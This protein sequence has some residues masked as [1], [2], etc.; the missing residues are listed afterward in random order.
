MAFTIT[1][2]IVSICVIDAYVIGHWTCNTNITPLKD[3]KT[4]FAIAKVIAFIIAFALVALCWVLFTHQVFPQWLT[5]VG[6]Q[7]SLA[8][9]AN[10]QDMRDRFIVLL[11]FPF[12][13]AGVAMGVIY[14]TKYIL[15]FIECKHT[16]CKIGTISEHRKSDI[17]ENSVFAGAGASVLTIIL[18]V[19]AMAIT[20]APGG[21]FIY[22]FD[23]LDYKQVITTNKTYD[24]K[25]L[26]ENDKDI[27]VDVYNW[28]DPKWVNI[29]TIT[30]IKQLPTADTNQYRVSKGYDTLKISDIWFTES[31]NMSGEIPKG[32]ED[33]AVIKITKVTLVSENVSFHDGTNTDVIRSKQDLK[34]IHI[35]YEVT[36]IDE[37]RAGVQNK[38][39]LKQF[40]GGE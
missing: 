33:K 21:E 28:R 9:T 39:E 23:R 26:Y 2:I 5:G 4:S 22:A 20:P 35:E 40:I 8:G 11:M 24:E 29:A 1:A 15:T 3:K 17:F 14:A 38:E 36:N 32:L 34:R 7:P 6:S 18:C 16:G 19:L 31:H 13:V 30:T 25:V 37:L 12:L 10:K 27:N